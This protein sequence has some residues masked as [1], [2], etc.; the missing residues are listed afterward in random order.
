M[1]TETEQFL[2][3]IF[4][5]AA[6]Y[7][8]AFPEQ[9]ANLV[10]SSAADIVY[11]SPEI[12]AHLAENV[13]EVKEMIAKRTQIMREQ[14]Y[15]AG[16]GY[17]QV[18]GTTLDYLSFRQDAPYRPGVST[19]YPAKIN[20][21]YTFDHEICHLVAGDSEWAAEAFAALRHRQ[22]FD[23][24]DIFKH[25]HSEDAFE[26]IFR[27]PRY[28]L[29]A[30]IHRIESIEKE[31]RINIKSLSLQETA[32]LAKD[33]AR[34]YALDDATLKKIHDAYQPLRTLIKGG[35]SEAQAISMI[36]LIMLENKDDHD[37]YRAGKL[38]LSAPD[39]KAF[40]T[41][42]KSGRENLALLEKH[43]KESGFILNAAD[44]KD[45]ARKSKKTSS[46]KLTRQ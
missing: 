29:S 24:T 8:S 32:K 27:D 7:R 9:L 22:R 11:A 42:T 13:A 41:A 25:A 18:K 4:N 45:A 39:V 38:Y 36:P 33:I 31:G 5:D 34:D 40:I 28:Y 37:I 19:E 17:P 3:E 1:T 43:E 2:T 14:D 23:K 35:A 46:L 44:A 10:I 30:V 20:I 26:I 12:A 6:Y 15:A 16:A 21:I